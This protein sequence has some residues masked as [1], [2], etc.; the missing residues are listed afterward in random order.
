MTTPNSRSIDSVLGELNGQKVFFDKLHGNNGD[1]LISM[2]GQVSLDKAGVKCVDRWQEGTAIVVTGGAGLSSVWGGAYAEVSEYCHGEAGKLPLVILPSTMSFESGDFADS[3]RDRQGRTVVFAREQYTYQRLLDCKFHNVEIG[4]DHD[5]AFALSDSDFIN[6]LKASASQRHL[7]V[8]E[9]RDAEALSGEPEKAVAAPGF[10]KKI[11]PIQFKRTYK[12]RKHEAERK[13]SRFAKW[14]HQEIKNFFPTADSTNSRYI[15]VSLAGLV[16]FQ[17]FCDLVKNAS[18]VATTRLHVAILAALLGK[19]TLVIPGSKAY[20]K[21]QGIYEQSLKDMEHVKI[22][23][24]PFQ[25]E[26]QPKVI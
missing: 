3:L 18:V 6:R 4:L 5:M 16:S 2:G 24:N 15:D 19:P 23:E 12:L 7:L 8:V 11:V 26:E 21:I 20:G 14:V 22:V 17:N 1:R 25:S 10:L 13:R 9:R